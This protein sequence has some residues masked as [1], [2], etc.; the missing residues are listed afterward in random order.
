M[1][2]FFCKFDDAK[3]RPKRMNSKIWFLRPKKT[4][5][6]LCGSIYLPHRDRQRYCYNCKLWFHIECLLDEETA[7]DPDRCIDPDFTI[8]PN[9]PV[10]TESMEEDELSQLLDRVL[11][12]PAVR[13]HGGTRR[14]DIENNWLNTGSGVQRG[15][16]AEWEKKDE[17][18]G[19]WVRQLGEGFLEDF[20]GKSWTRYRCLTCGE[21]GL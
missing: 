18:P 8:L 20:L 13:G 6:T 9:P 5:C 3:V 7:V 16:I 12:G 14:F 17:I 10:N 15:V 21:D 4:P 19:D 11:E 2:E 1:R